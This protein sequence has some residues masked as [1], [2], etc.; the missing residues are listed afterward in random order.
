MHIP[1]I[2]EGLLNMRGGHKVLDVAPEANGDTKV[3]KYPKDE[4]ISLG[5]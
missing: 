3:Q 2:Y 1:A 5:T 4:M